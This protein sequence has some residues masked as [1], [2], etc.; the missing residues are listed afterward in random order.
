MQETPRIYFSGPGRPSRH[1][2]MFVNIDTHM[3]TP[4]HFRVL[5]NVYR[6]L[7]KSGYPEWT[8]RW[9]IYDLLH[10]GRHTSLPGQY[11]LKGNK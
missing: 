9:A 4:Q 3:L 8:A 6:R 7:R 5:R 11:G 1:M 2:H 10:L